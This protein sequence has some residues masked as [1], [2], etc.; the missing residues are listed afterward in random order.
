MAINNDTVSSG[1]QVTTTRTNNTVNDANNVADNIQPQYMF[2]ILNMDLFAVAQ[3]K[4]GGVSVST[5]FQGPPAVAYGSYTPDANTRYLLVSGTDDVKRV[6][7]SIE[8]IRGIVAT[9][10]VTMAIKATVNG[11]AFAATDLQVEYEIF[12]VSSTGVQT[13]K[14]G[15]ATQNLTTGGVWT[16]YTLYSGQDITS[17]SA[18]GLCLIRTQF[19][20]NTD[21][22]GDD[23]EIE[24]KQIKVI[25]HATNN[26]TEPW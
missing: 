4:V 22:N 24:S 25:R 15:A 9:V 23:V 8:F 12:E 11:G 14:V 19:R 6:A 13:S 3:V 18:S 16:S 5:W 1:D 10:D 17:V 26:N 7:G 21:V 2:P 20:V